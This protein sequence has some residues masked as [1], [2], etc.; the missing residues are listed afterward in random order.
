MRL[1]HRNLTPEQLSSKQKTHFSNS[2]PRRFS[3]QSHNKWLKMKTT[4]I[5]TGG[6][7]EC[8]SPAHENPAFAQNIGQLIKRE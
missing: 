1:P 3:P 2:T 5:R 4:V 7:G 6:L 8:A